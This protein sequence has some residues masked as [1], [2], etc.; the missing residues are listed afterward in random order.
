MYHQCEFLLL[1]LQL[2]EKVDEKVRRWN[3]GAAT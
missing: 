1:V 2:M 3:D